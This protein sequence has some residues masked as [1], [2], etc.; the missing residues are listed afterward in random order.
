MSDA[1]YNP[2]E[3]APDRSAALEAA[4]VSVWDWNPASGHLR[5]RAHGA[6]VIPEIEGDWK[7]GA[8]QSLLKGLST[9]ALEG[10]L[11]SRQG[12]I[13]LLLLMADGRRFRMVG[14]R[15]EDGEA[16]GLLFLADAVDDVRARPAI[17]AVFQPIIR[18][19]DE[20]PVGFEA[21]ARWRDDDNKLRPVGEFSISGHPFTGSD[22]AIEMLR[23]TGDGLCEW[24]SAFPAHP[25][26]AQVNLT[27]SDLFQADVIQTVEDLMGQ[28]RFAK[29]A[30]RIELTEQAAL[31]DF[32]D[33]VAAAAALSASG[34]T[35]ILDD[36]GS[37][38][39][40]LAWLAAIPASAIKLDPQLTQMAGSPRVD[41][42]LKGV[43]K[44]ARELGM[45]IT[46]E[47]VEDKSKVAF[48]QNIGCDYVQGYA[49]ARPMTRSDVISYLKNEGFEPA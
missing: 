30:L 13:S 43:C 38:H 2:S 4:R 27:G 33:G 22:L 21:L 3:L 14:A 18:I 39:S 28:G 49:Y 44:L 34:V 7:L 31:R 46:A 25:V 45:S 5:I 11:T 24:S 19:A 42:V 26:H 6:A 23:Q 40:S 35:L 32:D 47:G 1:Q 36:F 41:T 12:H 9:R 8:F 20:K 48:L 29:E 37:G 16:R 15:G 10:A 17:E